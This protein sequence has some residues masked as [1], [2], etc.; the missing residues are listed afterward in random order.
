MSGPT[1]WSIF[2]LWAVHWIVEWNSPL[3]P[4]AAWANLPLHQVKKSQ[5]THTSGSSYGEFKGS[6]KL[7]LSEQIS[8]VLTQGGEEP[9]GNWLKLGIFCF[10]IQDVASV[11]TSIHTLEHT[12]TRAHTQSIHTHT[13]EHTHTRACTH[14]P[15]HAHSCSSED[16]FIFT[17]VNDWKWLLCT[18]ISAHTHVHT[19]V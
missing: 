15:E 14:T 16:L 2:T 8:T 6:G 12:H 10:M 5:G 19:C 4:P 11:Q 1:H 7:K 18:C 17:N 3:I 9:I 13:P